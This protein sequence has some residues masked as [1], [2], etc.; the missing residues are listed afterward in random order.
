MSIDLTNQTALVTGGNAGIGRAITTALAG[1]GATVMA[2]YYSS[3]PEPFEEHSDSIECVKLDATDSAEVEGVFAK[4]AAGIGGSI[5]ILVNNAGGL[6]G[7]VPVSEMS[8]E[9][10]HKVVDVNFTSTFYC[11]RAVVDHMPDGGRIVNLSSL[12]AHDGGGAG[13]AIYSASKA[14]TIGFTRAVAKELAPRSIRVNAIAPGFIAD[15]P[16]HNEFTPDDTQVAIAAKTPLQ[17]GGRPDEVAAAALF[18]AA[19]ASSFVTGETLG[20]N[21]GLY[22]A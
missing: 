1:A 19:D 11:T 10:F 18:L 2:T 20:V 15:T 9:H 21:G 5:D 16:F 17:R 6:I 12:A 22:F 7:R 14:A 8:D 13:S 4:A 3:T